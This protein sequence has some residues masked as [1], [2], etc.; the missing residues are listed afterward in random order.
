[1]FRLKLWVVLGLLTL[2]PTLAGAWSNVVIRGED[3]VPLFTFTN[4]GYVAGTLNVSVVIP[5]VE[6]VP[7][8]NRNRAGDE[9]FTRLRPGYVMGTMNATL[10][11]A[12]WPTAN[13][14]VNKKMVSD[15][16][17]VPVKL[18]TPN[19]TTPYYV[20]VHN[21]ATTGNMAINGVGVSD[22]VRV[23]VKLDTANV[24]YIDGLEA[25]QVANSANVKLEAIKGYVDGIELLLTQ[26]K[27]TVAPSS[28]MVSLVNK[29][30]AMS[31]GTVSSPNVST[32][33]FKE[34]LRTKRTSGSGTA[35]TTAVRIVPGYVGKF[36][37]QNW[38][39]TKNMCYALTAT[40]TATTGVTKL[41]AGQKE[42]IDCGTTT[43]WFTVYGINGPVS[44]NYTLLG[45]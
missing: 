10:T 39:S 23:P 11:P 38:G 20:E 42:E 14:A 43:T 13:L 17:P 7:S 41:A 4:P 44:Y 1:M 16:Q 36:Q 9:I 25:G 21:K 45:Y 24:G 26:L 19:A 6:T 15:T 37:I 33:N 40:A 30:A 3:Q 5:A 22:T 32:G 35:S 34:A 28:S 29:L 27:A 18:P 8:Y 31:N 12:T 2:I